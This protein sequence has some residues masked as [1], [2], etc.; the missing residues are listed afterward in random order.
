MSNKL[1]LVSEVL[2]LSGSTDLKEV[3]SAFDFKKLAIFLKMNLGNTTWS[4]IEGT[5]FMIFKLEILYLNQHIQKLKS[6]P[7][8]YQSYEKSA[9]WDYQSVRPSKKKTKETIL[10]QE[11]LSP[12][13]KLNFLNSQPKTLNRAQIGWLQCQ[14]AQKHK[15]SGISLACGWCNTQAQYLL[16]I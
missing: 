3:E 8:D 2:H 14:K 6:A 9:L 7:W 15:I 12:F 5:V 10:S 13:L 11:L 16:Q 1:L 4:D